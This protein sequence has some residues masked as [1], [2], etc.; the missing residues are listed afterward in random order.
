M[1]NEHI[2]VIRKSI[3]LTKTVS[4]ALTYV[5]ECM[6]GGK[7][8]TCAGVFNDTVESIVMIDTAI[9]PLLSD[10]KENEVNITEPYTE[11][12]KS[13]YDIIDAYEAMDQ[14]KAYSALKNRLIPA[15]ADW[16]K[17]IL[18]YLKHYTMS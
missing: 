12:E 8:E 5:E 4:E 6:R 16:Q 18:R 2:D 13:V 14:I 3:E 10:E 9:R 15:F 17:G 1:K 7:M 11:V